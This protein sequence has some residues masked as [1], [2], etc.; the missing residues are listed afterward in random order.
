MREA[1]A[2]GAPA[3]LCFLRAQGHYAESRQKA[4]DQL[5]L[6]LKIPY[7]LSPGRLKI[8]PNFVPLR[9]NPRFQRLLAD[10]T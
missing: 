7:Y 4:L 9:G 3:F 5:E 6:L 8:D 1:V 10:T 2:Q